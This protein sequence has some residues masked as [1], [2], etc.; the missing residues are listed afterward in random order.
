VS[1]ATVASD[2][3]ID[4]SVAAGG[5]VALNVADTTGFLESTK[6]DNFFGMYRGGLTAPRTLTYTF[7]VAGYTNLNLAMDWV[8]SGDIPDPGITITCSLDGA[9]AQTV[10]TVGTVSTAWNETMENGTVLAHPRSAK[11]T[12]NGVTTNSL[13]DVFQTYNPV[14]AG[15]GSVLTVTFS[16]TSSVGGPAY[17]MDNLKLYGTVSGTVVPP[18]PAIGNMT[19]TMLPGGTQVALSWLTASGYSYGVKASTNLPGGVWSNI[20]T[21]VP[22]T[23]GQ[24]TVT[25]AISP[26]ATFYRAFAE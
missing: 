6:T 5:A 11:V 8:A 26:G 15:T 12:V 22:G 9:A 16:M 14:I 18:P 23:G 7:N 3:V 25:N 1:R 19:I 13:S 21:N 4:T 20:I 2:Y 10:F 24:V 17:G